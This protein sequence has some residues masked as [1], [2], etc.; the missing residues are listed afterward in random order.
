MKHDSVI[1]RG[2]YPF[3]ILSLVTTIFIAFFGIGWLTILFAF[4]TFFIIWF[5]RNPDRYFQD[6]EKVLISPADGKIIKIE[7]VE[8]DGT[9]SGK[10][11]K[12]SIFMNVFNVH[13]NRAP[14]S[15]EIEAINYH[16]GKFFS[17][18][19]DKASLDN[20]RN[21][22]MIRTEDGRSLWM[23]QIAGLIA[24]RIVCWVNVGTIVK[25]GE[26]VG[27]IRFGSRVDVYLPD[28]SRILVKLKDKVKAGETVLGYLS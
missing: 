13:V 16:E 17:A 6:E 24:R 7:D 20:E 22:I 14:Y 3:I 27:L 8:V 18:N 28:D 5:F 26:R 25:K 15:G 10:F 21:E 4:I 2:G 11:K 19:L 9:I 1:A 23:V 12:I